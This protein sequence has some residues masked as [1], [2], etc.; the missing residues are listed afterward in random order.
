MLYIYNKSGDSIA[1]HTWADGCRV[2]LTNDLFMDNLQE[3]YPRFHFQI[4]LF[5]ISPYPDINNYQNPDSAIDFSKYV[6]TYI[7]IK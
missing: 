1:L 2:D 7:I 6:S 4:G 5:K 3:M